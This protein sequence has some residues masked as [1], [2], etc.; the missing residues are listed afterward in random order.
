MKRSLTLILCMALCL[1]LSGCASD[2]KEAAV[3]FSCAELADRVQAAA[4]FQELTDM[5]E[6]YLEKYLMVEAAD[7]DEWV[8]RRDATRATPEM[9][10]VVNVKE[11]ADLAAVEGMIQAFQEEQLLQYRDYQPD[12]V[13]KLENAKALENGRCLALIVSPDAANTNAALGEGWV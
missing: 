8:F 7:L 5:N 9:I 13:F 11:G 6:K 3:A 4:A 10:L 2:K 1:A 12:Q